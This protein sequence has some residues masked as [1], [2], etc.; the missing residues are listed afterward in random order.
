MIDVTCDH[1]ISRPDHRPPSSQTR[2]TEKQIR[3]KDPGSVS[4]GTGLRWG[5]GW[6]LGG[7]WPGLSVTGG[8][9]IEARPYGG[10]GGR[11]AQGW[12]GQG[13]QAWSTPVS[14][15]A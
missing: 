2:Q 4:E 13:L 5:R 14:L 11:H 15:R 10:G 7:A 8:Q 1:Y 12:G 6:S 3:S 9:K